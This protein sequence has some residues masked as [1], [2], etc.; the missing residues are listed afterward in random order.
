MS[1]QNTTRKTAVMQGNGVSVKF[2]FSFRINDEEDLKVYVKI[3]L[4]PFELKELETDYKLSD[5]VRDSNN[6]IISGNIEY[7]IIIAGEPNQPSPLTS[8]DSIYGIRET[9]RNQEESSEQVSF[10]SKDVERALDKATMQI[11]ELTEDISRAV[12]T[13]EWQDIDPD[14]IIDAIYEAEGQC[15]N[16]ATE[17]A[18]SASEASGYATNASGYATNASNSATAASNSATAASNAVTSCQTITNNAVASINRPLLSFI[19]S[20]HL[21]NNLAWLRADT[22]SWQ[23]GN[24]YTAVYE[25]L[26]ED[27]E[28]AKKTFYGWISGNPLDLSNYYT[29]SDDP[30]IGDTIFEVEN[31]TSAVKLTT[32]SSISGTNLVGANGVL[33]FRN[34]TETR[35]LYELSQVTINSIDI[36]YYQAADD[37]KIVASLNE[38]DVEDLYN[39]TGVAWYYVLDTANQRFKLPRTKYGFTGLRD[40]VG[41]YV[42]PG[43]PKLEL[44]KRQDSTSSQ[45]PDLDLIYGNDGYTTANPATSGSTDEYMVRTFT[46]DNLTAFMA[47][48]DATGIYGNSTTVQPPATQMYLYFYVGN[49]SQT[50]TEQTAGLN[51]EL[52][53]GKVDLDGSNATFPH[54]VETYDDGNGNGYRVWSDKWCEQYGRTYSNAEVSNTI[55]L[56]KPYKDTNYTVLINHGVSGAYYTNIYGAHTDEPYDFTATSFKAWT[57][58]AAG[59]NNIQWYAFGYISQE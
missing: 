45:E 10:K 40:E 28:T 14:E 53:N 23:S 22:F 24:V 13:E 31:S 47:L 37:H 5:V 17:A 15:G 20:D 56:L 48:Y 25:H 29:L 59:V 55:N 16:Y 33:Y 41:K 57:Y 21:I 43:L 44:V 6:N 8:A 32:V 50:A 12:K 27:L 18:N 49:F 34:G 46:G 1:I 39:A 42:A 26:M 35:Q 2:P 52:F 3:G 54:I 58:P 19:W 11:Q 4:G 51:S 38:S 7:P 36:Y 9:P 30:S